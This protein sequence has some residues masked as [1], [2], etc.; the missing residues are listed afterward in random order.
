M[1]TV[2][3]TRGPIDGSR[4][5]GPRPPFGDRPREHA[6]ACH[7]LVV[8]A[9]GP[10][11]E[12]ALRQHLAVTATRHPCLVPL[13]VWITPVPM[14]H[15]D[16]RARDLVRGEALRPIGPGRHP[17]RAVVVSYADGVADLVLV[18]V[19]SAVP[20]PVL[21]PLAALLLEGPSAAEIPAFATTATTA[22]TRTA[23]S[24]RAVEWGLGNP[25]QAGTTGSVPF[26]LPPLAGSDRRLLLG[27]VALTLARYDQRDTVEIGALA[28]D[29][30]PYRG[31][32]GDDAL[33]QTG[34]AVD[35]GDG[36]PGAGADEPDHKER[37]RE[38]GG[39]RHGEVDSF[40]YRGTVDERQDLST[41]LAQFS[42]AP[43]AARSA[44]AVGVV[45]GDTAEATGYLPCLAPLFP[46]TL[47][48]APGRTVRSRGPASTRARSP[49]RSPSS[50]APTSPASRTGSPGCPPRRRCRGSPS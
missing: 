44:P 13:R 30:G 35:H 43:V 8:R 40:V 19:R 48:A 36:E 1:T 22:T 41:L 3:R 37:E 14:G 10:L 9:P 17:I 29:G 16:S 5:A 18:A 21:G 25:R 26:A 23:P 27:A 39:E 12:A 6:R 34:S 46:L 49:R 11:D 24:R 50:S 20:Y 2:T 7:S 31:P 47:Y 32:L 15:T 45:F 38:D 42:A 4:T 33:A 28:Q